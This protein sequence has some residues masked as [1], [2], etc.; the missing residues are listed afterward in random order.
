MFQYFQRSPQ[1]SHPAAPH[2]ADLANYEKRRRSEREERRERERAAHHIMPIARVSASVP[3]PQQSRKMSEPMLLS[4]HAK[5]E[6]LDALASEL[7]KIGGLRNGR[8]R[9]ESMSPPPPAPPP[10]EASISTISDVVE[11]SEGRDRDR[12]RA[13]GEWDDLKDSMNGEDTLRG[14]N[15]PLPPTPTDGENTLVSDSRRN[16][17][18][19]GA[20][21]GGGGGGGGGERAVY[22]TKSVSE[23]CGGMRFRKIKFKTE[24][25]LQINQVEIIRK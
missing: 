21:G 5:P 15:K 22:K 23:V 12:E 10:R 8:S 24:N 7:S 6:D 1:Q 4:H 18:G 13:D 17:N 19:N 2:L 25:N 11:V 9:E 20:G 16:G 3:A 14:P